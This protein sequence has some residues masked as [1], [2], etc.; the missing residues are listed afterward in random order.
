M[1]RG[2]APSVVFVVLGLLNVGGAPAQTDV[3]NSGAAGSSGCRE[4]REAEN[5]RHNLARAEIAKERLDSGN[6]LERERIACRGNQS[7]NDAALERHGNRERQ[8]QI[9]DEAEITRHSKA[10]IDIGQGNCGGPA[11]A[12]SPAGPPNLQPYTE[13]ILTDLKGIVKHLLPD[14]SNPTPVNATLVGKLLF[15]KLTPAMKDFL[16]NQLNETAKKLNAVLGRSPMTAS[17]RAER[18]RLI[19]DGNNLRKAIRELRL[20]YDRTKN[21]LGLE[22]ATFPNSSELGFLY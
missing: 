19:S 8:L 9:R 2:F 13:T 11:P 20:A 17:D 5:R 10:N 3:F 15:L 14:P 6:Q 7:C 1:Q 12:A 4:A 21:E 18:D 22:A 16:T